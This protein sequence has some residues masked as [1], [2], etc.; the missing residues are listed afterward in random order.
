MAQ[1]SQWME[2]DGISQKSK[3]DAKGNVQHD[4]TT[5]MLYCGDGGLRMGCWAELSF[6]QTKSHKD[7]N[8]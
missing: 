3:Q 2:K 7:L 6:H 1:P 4:A 5:T 8:K